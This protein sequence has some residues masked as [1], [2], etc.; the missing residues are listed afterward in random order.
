MQNRRK[1]PQNRRKL[2]QNRQ[3]SPQNRRKSLQNCRKSPQ[4][5]R[6][7]LQNR[8]RIDQELLFFPDAKNL[9]RRCVTFRPCSEIN[10][11]KLSQRY[12]SYGEL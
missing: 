10:P 7:S 11:C 6:K 12:S 2:P 8:C 1:S 9:C 3:K 4:N 5:R